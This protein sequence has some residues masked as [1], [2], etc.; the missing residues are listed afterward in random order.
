MIDPEIKVKKL[1]RS[2]SQSRYLS[3]ERLNE[4]LDFDIRYRSNSPKNYD[5]SEVM[6]RRRASR[7]EYA[8]ERRYGRTSWSDLKFWKQL[9]IRFFFRFSRSEFNGDRARKRYESPGRERRRYFSPN[10]RARSISDEEN[11]QDDEQFHQQSKQRPYS[12][13]RD[14]P[15]GK[16]DR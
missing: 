6:R 7:E 1:S 10:N 16:Y 15:R 9:V 14:S 4:D 5:E 12:N 13:G 11:Y 2:I 8:E 3:Q